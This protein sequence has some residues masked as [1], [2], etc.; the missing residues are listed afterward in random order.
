M[1]SHILSRIAGNCQSKETPQAAACG[2]WLSMFFRQRKE[3]ETAPER[4]VD[5]G[6]NIKKICIKNSLIYYG[7]SIIQLGDFAQFLIGKLE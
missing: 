3:R 1:L 2:V 7:D 6:N 4:T 5:S